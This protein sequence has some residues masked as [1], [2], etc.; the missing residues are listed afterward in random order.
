M[1][2]GHWGTVAKGRNVRKVE[3]H[4]SR[5]LAA[6]R[7]RKYST[8]QHTHRC[9]GAN[10][11]GNAPSQGGTIALVYAVQL[12]GSSAG[13]RWL[14]DGLRTHSK[15][16]QYRSQRATS[17]L[18]SHRSEVMRSNCSE[19]SRHLERGMWK[20]GVTTDSV[21]TAHRGQSVNISGPHWVF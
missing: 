17:F 9:C 4:W 7:V 20:G 13:Q 1:V 16:V 8:D 5:C 19:N 3:N 6:W 2:G 14:G 11:R 12:T 18:S 21:Y 15:S 10:G